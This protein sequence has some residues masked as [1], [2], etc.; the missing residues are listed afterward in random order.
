MYQYLKYKHDALHKT[1]VTIAVIYH[2]I[3]NTNNEK[4]NVS[5]F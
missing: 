4:F 3:D 1:N 2:S 5:E